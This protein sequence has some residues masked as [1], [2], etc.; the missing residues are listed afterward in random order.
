VVL[1]FFRILSDDLKLKAYKKQNAHYTVQ[2]VAR[3]KKFR[4]RG[5]KTIS[6]AGDPQSGTIECGR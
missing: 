6:A 1:P 4:R 3:V 2:T 5:R